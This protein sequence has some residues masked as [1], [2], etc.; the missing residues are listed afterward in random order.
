MTKYHYTFTSEE[1]YITIYAELNKCLCLHTRQIFVVIHFL[2]QDTQSNTHS[3]SCHSQFFPKGI[4]AFW[5][6]KRKRDRKRYKL[7]IK[8]IF[9]IFGL[10]SSACCYSFQGNL[11]MTLFEFIWFVYAE[12]LGIP[13]NL[14]DCK[15]FISPRNTF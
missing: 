9:S 10:S 2:L 13:S 12:Y 5:Q 8:Y 11:G 6:V 7:C 14:A 3:V 1:K 15:I 4:D